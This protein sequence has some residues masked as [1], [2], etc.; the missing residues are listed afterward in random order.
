MNEAF[1]ILQ[2]VLAEPV[3]HAL[4]RVRLVTDGEQRWAGS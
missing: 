4:R 1:I 2:I 3:C